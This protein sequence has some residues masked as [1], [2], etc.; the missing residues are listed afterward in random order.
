MGF[1]SLKINNWK[2]FDAIDIEFHDRLTVLTGANAS[3]KTTLLNLL[4]G[5]FGWDLRELS[6]PTK[7]QETGR[8]EFLKPVLEPL[9]LIE[10]A[11]QGEWHTIGEVIYTDGSKTDITI[12][13]QSSPTYGL[14]FPSFKGPRGMYIPSD[15]PEFV[16]QSVDQIPEGRTRDRAFDMLNSSHKRARGRSRDIKEILI[17]WGIS[18]FD[19]KIIVGDKE[20]E[21]LYVGFEN[22][23]RKILPRELGFKEFSVRVFEVVLVTES[24]EFMIDGVS[25]GIGALID[26]A[27]RIYLLSGGTD[28]LT[29][30]LIDE[31]ETHLHASMQRE[32]MPSFLEAFPNVQFIISTHSPLVLSSVRDSSVYVLRHNDESKVESLQLDITNKAKDAVDILKDVLGVSFSMPVWVEEELKKINDKYLKREINEE[33][34]ASLRKELTEIGLEDLVPYSIDTILSS[35]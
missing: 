8:I 18:G 11:D 30:V 4:A 9:S 28:A 2:Q 34:F 13:Y 21:N 24:G 27:L 33:T 15:R 3:G 22:L 19:S 35:K 32:L 10:Q 16:Y 6:T 23:L 14:N 17:G 29:T 12:P 31:V 20:F 1:K 25:G 7:V 26:L 5:H